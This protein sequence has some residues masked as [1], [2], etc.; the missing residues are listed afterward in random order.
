MNQQNNKIILLTT[1]N[2]LF[3]II[4][5]FIN[6]TYYLLSTLSSSHKKIIFFNISFSFAFIGFL[7]FR[8]NES[9]DVYRYGLSLYY[10]GQSM[11]NG[12]E[13]IIDGVYESF[14]PIWYFILYITNKLDFNLQFIN[15]I[16]GFTIYSAFLYVILELDKKYKSKNTDKMLFV[17]VFLFISFVAIFSSYRTLWGFSLISIGLFLLMNDKRSGYLFLI[18]GAGFHPIAVFPIMIYIISKYFRFKII[19]LY[20]SLFIGLILKYFISIFNQFL[21]IP[22]IGDKINT[23]IY[24]YWA[25]YR[26]YNNSEYLKFLILVLFIIFIFY[27]VTFRFIDIKKPIDK[28]FKKYNDFIFWYFSI[29]LWFLSFRTIETRLLLDGIIF[30][31]PLFYQVFLNRKI[32]KKRLLSFSLLLIWFMI[33]DVRTFNFSNVSYLIGSGFPINLFDSPVY[34]IIKGAV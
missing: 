18:I 32:Y 21:N 24:G 16:A 14:Y 33:I 3:P 2:L 25:Q 22:F 19:Y 4:G 28:Y 8:T 5:F 20:I 23:Y 11:L 26:F 31:F 13:H 9:G 34:L 15:L 30:F 1:S 27:V 6:S 10:Y 7:Y 29:S 12:R 17:K